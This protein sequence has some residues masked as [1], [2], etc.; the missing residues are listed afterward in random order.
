[1]R[2]ETRRME[3][4]SPRKIEFGFFDAG[5]GH[6]AAA[7]AL[8]QVVQSQQRPWDVRLVNLQELMEEID[9]A[10][11][12]AGIRIEVIYNRM[13]RNGWTLGSPQ[14]LKVLQ[15]AIRTNHGR[16]VKLLER[17]WRESQPDM[18]VSFVPHFNRAMCEA[19][20]KARPGVPFVTVI[21]DIA[22]YPPK[23]WIEQQRQ[24]IVCGSDK[25]MQQARG[26]GYRED[27]LFRA[28]GMILNPKF[29]DMPA[30]DRSAERAALGL[31]PDLPTGLVMF[32]GFGSKVML[33]IAERLDAS[34]LDL[35]LLFVCGRNDKLTA[36]LRAK[37]WRVPH[38]IEG[39]TTKVNTYMQAADFFIGKPG[40][41]S[42][43]EALAMHL[44]VIVECNAW[45][46]PQ[47]RYNAEWVVENN[48][49]VC[50]QSFEEIVPATEKLIAPLTL[51]RYRANAA[52]MKIAPS[53]KSP[54]FCKASSNAKP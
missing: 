53:S 2:C 45:T 32:G 54:N 13:L 40:P 39:F 7:T 34:N 42:V 4:T 11:K 38:F 17:H 51:S 3:Q 22:N 8:E 23:F 46:L 49:G 44:P 6:R 10:K 52:A 21:T 18:V 48:V 14:L 31:R 26:E 33:E 20:A 19:L 1:M 27:E 36:A 41:G 30:V 15:F 28:S 12:Y 29:Y 5:G 16:T 47:E 24:F 25:A 37:K 43:S 35:Q 9:I 50:L